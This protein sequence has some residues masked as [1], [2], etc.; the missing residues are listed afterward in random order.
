[1]SVGLTTSCSTAS[2]GSEHIMFNG[3]RGV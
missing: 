2:V 3:E 1:V